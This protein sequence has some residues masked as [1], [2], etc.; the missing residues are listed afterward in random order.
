MQ[1]L[2]S[3]YSKRLHSVRQSELLHKRGYTCC[4]CSECMHVDTELYSKRTAILLVIIAATSRG[5]MCCSA[6]LTPGRLL[7]ALRQRSGHAQQLQQQLHNCN[8]T[9]PIAKAVAQHM[10]FTSRASSNRRKRT[11]SLKAWCRRASDVSLCCCYI[12]WLYCTLC[13]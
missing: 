1:W 11:A 5:C 13:W 12:S 10:L 9:T 7:A 4:S 3:V 2:C 8:N 6:A